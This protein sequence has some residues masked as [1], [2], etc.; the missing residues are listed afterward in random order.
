MPTIERIT[1]LLNTNRESFG[2]RNVFPQEQSVFPNIQFTYSGRVVKWIVGATYSIFERDSFPELQIWR[3]TSGSTFQKQSGTTL[4]ALA[5]AVSGIYEFLVQ[6]PLPF[7]P[8]D[9]LGL[10]QPSLQRSKLFVDFEVST[11]AAYYYLPLDE[12]AVEPTHTF[13]D[14]AIGGWRIGRVL[15]LVTVEIGKFLFTLH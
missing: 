3:P 8:G 7:Q 6:P 11:N 4:T 13:I 1:T 15:P 10:F 2:F 12:T 14:I 5:D 9:V